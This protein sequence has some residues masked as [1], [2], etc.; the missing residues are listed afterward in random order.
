[1]I[2]ILYKLTLKLKFSY[3]TAM[4]ICGRF[5]SK[6]VSKII[7]SWKI[8]SIRFV[9][10]N[11]MKFGLF[12]VQLSRTDYQDKGNDQHTGLVIPRVGNSSWGTLRLP[13]ICLIA[14]IK[15]RNNTEWYFWCVGRVMMV[16]HAYYLRSPMLN[17]NR[18]N[19]N[20]HQCSWAFQR[21]F[22]RCTH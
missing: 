20:H 17:S 9:F 6:L 4:L 11:R 16:S 7:F 13:F 22:R 19:S 18:Q 8:I 10:L 12:V 14:C 21:D 3:L 15:Y 5:C 1:M 2:Y